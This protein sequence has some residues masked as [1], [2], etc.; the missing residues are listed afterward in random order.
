M[1][2]RLHLRGILHHHLGHDEN[3][4]KEGPRGLVETEASLELE[5]YWNTSDDP[6]E[7][8]EEIS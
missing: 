2:L 7:Q 6:G 4:L 1:I 8:Q 3:W 5:R